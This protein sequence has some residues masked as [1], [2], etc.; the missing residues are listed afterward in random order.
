MKNLKK[1]TLILAILVVSTISFA[2][3]SAKIITPSG[4]EKIEGI[5]TTEI[6]ESEEA[7]IV[8]EA[9]ETIVIKK[10]IFKTILFILIATIYY[11]MA[12]GGLVLLTIFNQIDNGISL[13]AGSIFFLLIMSPLDN[14][15][16]K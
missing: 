12:F 16:S 3:D 1:T 11:V 2:A 14:W 10:N 15:L 9:K 13:M 4:S 8:E 7:V 5:A 6:A